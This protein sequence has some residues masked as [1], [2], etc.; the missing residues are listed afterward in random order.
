[1]LKHDRRIKAVL[2]TTLQSTSGAKLDLSRRS[3]TLNA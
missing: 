2:I 3:I 1:V